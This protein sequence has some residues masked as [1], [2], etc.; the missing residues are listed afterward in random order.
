MLVKFEVGLRERSTKEQ[1]HERGRGRRVGRPACDKPTETKQAV[2]IAILAQATAFLVT[3]SKCAPF[4]LRRGHLVVHVNDGAGLQAAIA[5]LEPA[6]SSPTGS[7]IS[8]FATASRLLFEAGPRH[9]P[10]ARSLR[11]LAMRCATTS[12]PTISASP[13]SATPRTVCAA[14]CRT[15]S[16]ANAPSLSPGASPSFPT[17]KHELRDPAAATLIQMHFVMA[18]SFAAGEM[19]H[20]GCETL[21]PRGGEAADPKL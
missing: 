18:E 12:T 2:S 9:A 8:G 6:A 15:S 3:M 7:S 16:R 19:G 21:K 11:D 20:L 1:E 13:N 17:R 5:A 4:V 10:E 14:T